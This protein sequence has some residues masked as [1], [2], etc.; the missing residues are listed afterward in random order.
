MKARIE[1]EWDALHDLT[2]ETMH[3]LASKAGERW[4]GCTRRDGE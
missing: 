4:S 3:A 2:M 1:E